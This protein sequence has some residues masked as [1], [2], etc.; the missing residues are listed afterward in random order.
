MLGG[1]HVPPE[2]AQGVFDFR[3]RSFAFGRSRAWKTPF[4]GPVLA[5]SDG[6]LPRTVESPVSNGGAFAISDRAAPISPM[7][8]V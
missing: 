8:M 4:G 3:S 6:K 2:L 5:Q 1:G 7:V